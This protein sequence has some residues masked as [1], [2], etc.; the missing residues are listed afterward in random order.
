MFRRMLYMEVLQGENVCK[1]H[2]VMYVKSS[3]S[4]ED[5]SRYNIPFYGVDIFYLVP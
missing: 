1:V 3:L 2:N 5:V 4:P